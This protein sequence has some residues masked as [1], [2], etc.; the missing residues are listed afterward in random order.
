M[1]ERK[2]NSA[3][4]RDTKNRKEKMHKIAEEERSNT[5]RGRKPFE[6]LNYYNMEIENSK[7]CFLM[8]CMVFFLSTVASLTTLFMRVLTFLSRQKDSRGSRT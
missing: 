2:K 4:G 3:R 1:F 8:Y 6:R 5:I 7:F